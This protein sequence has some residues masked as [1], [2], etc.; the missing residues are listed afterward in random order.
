[1]LISVVRVGYGLIDWC[2]VL[3]CFCVVLLSLSLSL[4][5]SLCVS[6]SLGTRCV[7][8]LSSSTA[9]LLRLRIWERIWESNGAH[10]YIVLYI[11]LAVEVY[12]YIE[13]M[14]SILPSDLMI[15]IF[16]L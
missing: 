8:S 9:S 10:D 4:S 5:L 6:L 15:S 12:I 13:L 16:G 2:F 7:S 3:F 11:L 14:L 1:V